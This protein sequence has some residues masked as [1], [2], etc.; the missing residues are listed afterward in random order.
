ME[1]E[2][3]GSILLGWDLPN[4]GCLG[5]LP[6]ARAKGKESGLLER[7]KTNISSQGRTYAELD[8]L[9]EHEVPARKFAKTTIDPY[10]HNIVPM[11]RA[12]NGTDDTD[13]MN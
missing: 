4:L 3:S 7:D 5:V 10:S 9:F 6:L 12:S 8:L 1:L 11:K 2:Q 13:T